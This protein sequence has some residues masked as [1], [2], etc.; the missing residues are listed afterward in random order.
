MML[1]LT[2]VVLLVTLVEIPVSLS[3]GKHGRFQQRAA[4]A[5][6]H[7]RVDLRGTVMV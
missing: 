2:T 5:I 3:Q 4:K 1:R 7:G 6:L